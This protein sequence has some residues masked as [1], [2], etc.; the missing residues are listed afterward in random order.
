VVDEAA[1]DPRVEVED[2]F[3]EAEAVEDLSSP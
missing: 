3:R 2:G 1:R